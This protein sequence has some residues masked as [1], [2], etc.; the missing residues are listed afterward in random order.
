MLGQTTVAVGRYGGEE[1]QVGMAPMGE[2]TTW[3]GGI[4]LVAA[5]AVKGGEG[6]RDEPPEPATPQEP[7]RE[8]RRLNRQFMALAA[9]ELASP[10]AAL[11]QAVRTL[12]DD[13]TGRVTPVAVNDLEM[14]LRAL[15]LRLDDLFGVAPPEEPQPE[16]PAPDKVSG[17]VD[18]SVILHQ[19]V[20][21][22]APEAQRLHAPL[23][24]EAALSVIGPWSGGEMEGLLHGLLSSALT[25]GAGRPV[26]LELTLRD[27]VARLVM[28]LYSSTEEGE[29]KFSAELDRITR[30]L[31]GVGGTAYLRGGLP[32]GLNLTIYLP[33][34]T[35]AAQVPMPDGPEGVA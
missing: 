28:G 7:S 2:G 9:Q 23:H 21:R 34:A 4:V 33:V 26:E 29:E 32:M 13:A 1:Y 10:V 17:A 35:A 31:A 14:K 11:G 27:D 30:E 20:R 6:E 24:L 3:R 22:L 19:L 16:R 18:L 8:A 5:P 25:T 15:A 12:G